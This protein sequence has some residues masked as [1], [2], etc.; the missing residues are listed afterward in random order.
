MQSQHARSGQGGDAGQRQIPA[1]QSRLA[2]ANLHA[3]QQTAEDGGLFARHS[4]RTASRCAA[5]LAVAGLADCPS[6]VRSYL[7]A[8]SSTLCFS[9]VV[10]A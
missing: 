1:L 7:R 5:A 10:I 9:V 4:R 8:T 6:E 2:Q 3:L